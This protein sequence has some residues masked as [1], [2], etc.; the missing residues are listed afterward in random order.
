MDHS[1]TPEQPTGTVARTIER[2]NVSLARMH[3]ARLA[4]SDANKRLSQAQLRLKEVQ[5]REAPRPG[6]DDSSME[7][8]DT[9]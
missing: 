5:V 1:P 3:E 4:L 6:M 7:V 2:L 9:A 8:E